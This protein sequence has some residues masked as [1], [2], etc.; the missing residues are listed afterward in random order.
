MEAKR[1]ETPWA[2][3]TGKG[4]GSDRRAVKIKQDIEERDLM[5][6]PET[7]TIRIPC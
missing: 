2:K 3:T 5:R 7:N 4:K 1:R 6:G